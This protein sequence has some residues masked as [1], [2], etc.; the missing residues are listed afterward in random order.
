MEPALP[1]ANCR[2]QKSEETKKM[3]Y[4]LMLSQS[5]IKFSPQI[6]DFSFS[7]TYI[8]QFNIRGK[9]N[10]KQELVG[11]IAKR[12]SDVLCNQET[13]LS[14]QTNS[15]LMNY[16]GLFKEGHTNIRAHGG[17][18]IL[19][20]E[21]IPHQKVTLNSQL[22]AIAARINIGRNVTIVSIYISRS[23][24][25][26]GKLLSTVFQQRP[27]PVIS[28][29]YFNIYNQIWGSLV[30]DDRGDK[31]LGFIIKNQ[32]KILND[33]SHTRKSDISL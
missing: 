23:H 8:I 7:S 30:N 16:T 28:T 31:V 33:G 10:K 20:H 12:K 17:V 11:I 4:Q 19:I 21:T 13:I 25:I 29:G 24:V 27:K 22:H 26:S 15:K 32:P 1:T 6:Q 3:K 18:A 2:R 5:R 14:K 9:G